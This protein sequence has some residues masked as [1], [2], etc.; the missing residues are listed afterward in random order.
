[1][2]PRSQ[3]ST[4]R[5]R[6]SRPLSS[7]R[8]LGGGV[9]PR[10]GPSGCSSVVTCVA[11]LAARPWTAPTACREPLP[12]TAIRRRSPAVPA[13]NGRVASA[14]SEITGQ[15]QRDQPQRGERHAACCKPQRDG[16][17]KT[18]VPQPGETLNELGPEPAPGRWNRLGQRR[19]QPR[20]CH[21]GDHV[22]Q[23]VRDERTTLGRTR[24]RRYVASRSAPTRSTSS[25]ARGGPHCPG[26]RR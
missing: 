16:A 11:A 18:V 2:S 20:H 6:R 14:R 12:P 25:P 22:G 5:C 13:G 9:R 15:H 7:S 3:V 1:M 21:Q 10:R 19:S 4:A 23:R 17:Q 26:Q 8:P 24:R